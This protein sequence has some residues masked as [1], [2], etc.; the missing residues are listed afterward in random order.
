MG[1]EGEKKDFYNVKERTPK[2]FLLI[3]FLNGMNPRISYLF[4][5]R[6]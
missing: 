3:T 6:R 5:H 4:S 2:H 1:I